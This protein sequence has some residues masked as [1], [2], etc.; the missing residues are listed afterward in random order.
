MFRNGSRRGAALRDALGAPLPPSNQAAHDGEIAT[1]RRELGGDA[2][3]MA[4]QAGR[5]APLEQIV[6]DA[7]GHTG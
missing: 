3:A 5:A 6:D 2:F 4:W 1:L 7:L